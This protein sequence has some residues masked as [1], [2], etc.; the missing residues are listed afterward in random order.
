MI[1]VGLHIIDYA[2]VQMKGW[3]SSLQ[4]KFIEAGALAILAEDI[5][6]NPVSLN[7]EEHLTFSGLDIYGN[8]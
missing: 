4:A 2:L 6:L 7:K 1:S 5:Y 3:T 8:N